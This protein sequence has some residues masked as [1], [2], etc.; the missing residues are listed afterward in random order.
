M[1]KLLAGFGLGPGLRDHRKSLHL[2]QAQLAAEVGLAE[3]TIRLLER[4]RGNLISWRAVMEHL[5][6][7]LLGRNLPGGASLGKRLTTLRRRRGLSQREL[8]ELVLVA[9]ERRGQG[10]VSTLDRVLAAL[11]AGAVK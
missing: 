1:R 9:L 8:A 2:T 11:G 3:R 10:R 4:G 6:L 5:D 7:Q